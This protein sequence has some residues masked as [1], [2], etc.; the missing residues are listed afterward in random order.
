MRGEP[1]RV[2]TAGARLPSRVWGMTHAWFIFAFG[3]EAPFFVPHISTS[4]TAPPFTADYAVHVCRIVDG[5][6]VT[7]GI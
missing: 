3:T 2:T 6:Q 4:H 5:V 7:E 1:P